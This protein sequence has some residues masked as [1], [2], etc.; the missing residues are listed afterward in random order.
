MST[1]AVLYDKK[2]ARDLWDEVL[3]FVALIK[4]I[5]PYRCRAVTAFE[6][7]FNRKPDVKSL[8]IIGSTG[9]VTILLEVRERRTIPKIDPCAEKCRLLGY[10]SIGK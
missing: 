2:I 1:C 9:W 7:R 8:R 5:L 4:N 10:T 6:L 3:K